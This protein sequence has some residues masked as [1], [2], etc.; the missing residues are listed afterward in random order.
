MNSFRRLSYLSFDWVASLVGAI[1]AQET[2]AQAADAHHVAD[3]AF[4]AAGMARDGMERLHNI[5]E[6]LGQD[7]K[8]F[9]LKQLEDV[10]RQRVASGDIAAAASDEMATAATDDKAKKQDDKD[11]DAKDE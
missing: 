8:N 7:P 2:K 9:G 11:T 1:N 10:L 5:A 3:L 4:G 6:I